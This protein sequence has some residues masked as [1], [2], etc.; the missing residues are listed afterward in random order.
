MEKEP[1]KHALENGIDRFLGK[2][3]PKIVSYDAD[4][5]VPIPRFHNRQ[6]LGISSDVSIFKGLDLWTAFEVSFLL[7]SGL[8]VVGVIQF[9]VPANSRNIVESKSVK[10]Y[11]SSFNSELMGADVPSA[12]EAFCA[13][14]RAD[15]SRK[16]GD[17]VDVRWVTRWEKPAYLSNF[18]TL[19]GKHALLENWNECIEGTLDVQSS[20]EVKTIQWH[21]ALLRSQ[22]RIT[23]Q[24]DWG[25]V[26]IE[27][28]G[29]R[30]PS[31][32]S[33][34]GHIIS[35]REEE[36]FHEE[37]VESIFVDLLKSCE[38]EQ[39]LVYAQ[40]TRRGGVDIN[41][42]RCLHLERYSGWLTGPFPAYKPTFRQ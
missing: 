6:N 2:A 40:Y 26:F 29:H 22:C 21:S 16:T 7:D 9:S 34:L 14:A 18:V 15:L 38:P 17:T 31:E 4:I 1:Q 33:M 39:L 5:L 13:R 10:L 25:D 37:I 11:L 3:S 8:P 36:H 23:Q 20:D 24:P 27:I 35:M 30:F 28:K 32:Q 12:V 42:L 19:E 41:P